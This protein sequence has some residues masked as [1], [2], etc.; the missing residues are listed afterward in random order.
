MTET[1]LPIPRVS[2]RSTRCTAAA[3]LVGLVAACGTATSSSEPVAQHAAHVSAQQQAA[4]TDALA[5]RSTLERLLG[6]HV[7]ARRRVRPD[8]GHRQG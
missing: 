8:G 3:V 6:A 4:P 5:L 1:L 7:P 2:A